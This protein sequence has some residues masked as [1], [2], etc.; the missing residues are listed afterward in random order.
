MD[1]KKFAV[2]RC[3]EE[4]GIAVVPTNWLIKQDK[5]LLWPIKYKKHEERLFYNAVIHREEPLIGVIKEWKP[6]DVARIYG[7]RG[8]Y[9]ILT[10]LFCT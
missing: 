2:V 3:V 9:N 5:L 6:L 10:S 1:E 8:K 7:K 4:K